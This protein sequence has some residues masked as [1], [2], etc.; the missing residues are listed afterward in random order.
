MTRAFGFPRRV[1]R[2]RRVIVMFVMVAPLLSGTAVDRGATPHP[3]QAAFQADIG[4]DD[5]LVV[6]T[7]WETRY[8]LSI[9][10]SAAG[11]GS[12]TCMVPFVKY[13]GRVGALLNKVCGPAAAYGWY[14]KIMLERL[15]FMLY[16]A[17]QWGGCGAFI[18]DGA[19]W[20]WWTNLRA[21]SDDETGPAFSFIT[22]GKTAAINGRTVTCSEY[23][24]P[25]HQSTILRPQPARPTYQGTHDGSPYT[26]YTP[27]TP[28][29]P[30]VGTG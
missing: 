14:T 15:R 7:P 25:V 10:T 3:V 12:P 11:G 16:I 28:L 21:A 6:M 24:D 1:S 19:P 18:T 29:T 22:P 5:T 30:P 2:I 27:I 8:M 20:R 4:H 17:T 26:P 23:A 9:L 13:I